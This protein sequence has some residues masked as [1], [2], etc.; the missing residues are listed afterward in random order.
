MVTRAFEQDLELSRLMFFGQEMSLEEVRLYTERMGEGC[1][2]GTRLLDL[3]KLSK[4]LPVKAVPAGKLPVLVVGG[5]KDMIVDREA[6]EETARAYGMDEP[7]ILKGVPHD[8]ML[9][10]KWVETADL[11]IDW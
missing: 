6:L 7:V 8:A 1:P 9:D 11:I 4:S 3:S 5:E 10:V 2:T